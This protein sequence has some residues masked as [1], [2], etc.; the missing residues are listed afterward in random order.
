MI[1]RLLSRL[2]RVTSSGRWIPEVDGLRF[3]AIA[4]VFIYHLRGYLA[5]YSTID[6]QSPVADDWLA[7]VT[8]YGNLG[9]QLFFTLSGFILA[10]PFA[11]HCFRNGR[12]VSLRAYSLRRLTRLEPPYL[13]T[14]FLFFGLYAATG[15]RSVAEMLP[16]LLANVFYVHNWFGPKDGSINTV[17][18]SLEIEVQFYLLAPLLA[19]LF[20]IPSRLARRGLV[21]AAAYAAV[22][23]QVLIL[24]VAPAAPISLLNYLQFFLM[25]FLAADIYVADWQGAP[26]R[27]ALWDPLLPLAGSAIVFLAMSRSSALP[28][29]L[30]ALMFVLIAASFRA[31]YGRRFLANP[32]ITAIGGMCYT[33]YLI[34]YQIISFVGRFTCDWAL[35]QTF[36]VNLLWQTVVI[37]SATVAISA[38][39]FLLV[40][41]PCMR[42]D[43]PRRL[44]M[45]IWSGLGSARPAGQPY[46][47]DFPRHERHDA[48][49]SGWKA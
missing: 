22:A 25:G 48:E 2:T 9:V 5:H 36:F 41:K 15:R 35:G 33:I 3:V 26:S 47:V 34:H 11:D 49:P 13:L 40:E 45:T 29:T 7:R 30:P 38:T 20:V 37:G 19:G 18:W 43:W 46:Q 31:D 42:P 4:A 21:V 32:M 16:N 27:S 17:A 10:L 12:P 23:L 28:W 44:W 6:W 24:D 8:E 14:L 39:F 1:R